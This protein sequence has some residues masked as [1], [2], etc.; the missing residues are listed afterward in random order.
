MIGMDTGDKGW[1]AGRFGGID[2]IVQTYRDPQTG[3]MMVSESSSGQ[4][5]HVTDYEEWYKKQNARGAKLYGTDVTKLAD[6]EAVK[7]WGGPGAAGRKNGCRV[8]RPDRARIRSPCG[9]SWRCRFRPGN[10]PCRW[11]PYKNCLPSLSPGIR[12]RNLSGRSP[13]RTLRGRM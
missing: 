12:T 4:G 9:D 3:R 13:P 5:V 7:N 11:Q 10:L 8:R 1:D 2:H 6:A